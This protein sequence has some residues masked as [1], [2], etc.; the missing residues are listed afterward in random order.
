[1]RHLVHKRIERP[2]TSR[3]SGFFPSYPLCPFG[4]CIADRKSGARVGGE[5]YRVAESKAV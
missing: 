1:M 2:E 3:P 5:G 4:G